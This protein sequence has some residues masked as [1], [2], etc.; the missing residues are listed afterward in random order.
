M[1][2]AANAVAAPFPNNGGEG[3]AVTFQANLEMC[4]R[5][6]C[7][8][9]NERDRRA[10]RD[11]AERWRLLILMARSKEYNVVVG[12]RGTSELQLGDLIRHFCSNPLTFHLMNPATGKVLG[13]DE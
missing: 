4:W 9:P 3:E 6:A 7:S 5:M 10:W 8:A 12:D 2:D 11:M 1:S 13:G